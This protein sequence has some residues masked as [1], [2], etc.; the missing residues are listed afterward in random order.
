MPCTVTCVMTQRV[1]VVCDSVVVIVG[2]PGRVINQP[3][4]LLPYLSN[5]FM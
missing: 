1:N 5:L 4:I 3:L 2:V